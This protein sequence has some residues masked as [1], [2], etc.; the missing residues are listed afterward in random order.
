MTL[1]TLV[2]VLFFAV[3]RPADYETWHAVWETPAVAAGTALYFVALL[4]HGWVGI[5]DIILDYAASSPGLRVTLL[6]LLGAWL[7]ILGVWM[8]EILL[9]VMSEWN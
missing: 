6:A 1:F 9:T 2:G 7:M 4:L 3:G 5:R 8:L